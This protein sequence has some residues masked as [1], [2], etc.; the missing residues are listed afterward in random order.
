[1]T[2][3]ASDKNACVEKDCKYYISVRGFTDCSYKLTAS[4]GSEAVALSDGEPVKGSLTYNQQLEYSFVYTSGNSSS[5]ALD[6]DVGFAS[7]L[8]AYI[9]LDNSRPTQAFHQY[10]LS[11]SNPHIAMGPANPEFLPCLSARCVVRMALI[12]QGAYTLTLTTGSTPKTLPYNLPMTGFL[13]QG[14]NAL[15]RTDFTIADSARAQLMNSSLHF[16]LAGP[17]TAYLSCIPKGSN[18]WPS[19]A[20]HN[21]T[22]TSNSISVLVLPLKIAFEVG[23]FRDK[24]GAANV[25]VV[26]VH[27]DATGAYSVQVEHDGSP[28]SPYTSVSLT[29][30]ITY[31]GMVDDQ[32][33][34]YFTIRPDDINKNL[35]YAHS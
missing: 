7:T 11:S 2:I 4:A 24:K 21:W 25:L 17:A 30:G 16:T 19:A 32:S 22:L 26:V 10:W 34:K 12:G 27:A 8:S 6:L 15:Y 33:L 31:T 20:S 9:T 18:K 5:I 23:C 14:Q 13:Q 3:D 35:R 28:S 29:A 1:M